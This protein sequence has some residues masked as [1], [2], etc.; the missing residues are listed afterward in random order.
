MMTIFVAILAQVD[1][2]TSRDDAL[3]LARRTVRPVLVHLD[4]G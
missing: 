1:W 4:D 3:A 2:M